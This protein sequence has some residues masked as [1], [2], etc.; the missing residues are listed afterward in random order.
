M[1]AKRLLVS[2]ELAWEGN[3][4][5]LEGVL[6]LARDRA[7]AENPENIL[8]RDEHIRARDL[9]RERIEVPEPGTYVPTP[10]VKEFQVEADELDDSW[11]RLQ[12]ERA[13]LDEVETRIIGM[14]LRRHHGVV[15][16]AAKELNVSRTSLLSR[17][18]T[19]KMDHKVFKK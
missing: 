13:A 9:G 2:P 10:V 12:R 8:L 7:L 16:H 17:M 14:A 11:A 18:A 19:L 3:I 1:P 4:R 5:E 6:Q 15:A